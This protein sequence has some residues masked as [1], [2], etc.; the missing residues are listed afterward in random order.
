MSSGA[1]MPIIEFPDGLEQ[2]RRKEV[3]FMALPLRFEGLDSVWT[4]AIAIEEL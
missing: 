3:F 4:R 2:L 1:K